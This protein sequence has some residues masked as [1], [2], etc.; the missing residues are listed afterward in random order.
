MP[1]RPS[2]SLDFQSPKRLCFEPPGRKS[3]RPTSQMLIPRIT[4]LG[5]STLPRPL[6]AATSQPSARPAAAISPQ[7]FYRVPEQAS[8]DSNTVD[9]DRERAN[10]AD[11]AI[12][13][14]ATLRFINGKSSRTLECNPWRLIRLQAL[15]LRPVVST[16]VIQFVQVRES[17]PC[18]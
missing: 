1:I 12:R 4:R 15:F 13:Y 5:I 7:A 9:M 3:W 17:S 2:D 10:F 16:A 14:E 11:N 6:A 18:H 8:G